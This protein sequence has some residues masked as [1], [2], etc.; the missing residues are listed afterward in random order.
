MNKSFPILLLLVLLTACSSDDG[1]ACQTQIPVEIKEGEGRLSV[2]WQDITEDRIVTGYEFQLELRGELPN[3]TYGSTTIP[4]TT[5]PDNNRFFIESFKSLPF[6]TEFD[7][8]YRVMC[9]NNVGETLGPIPLR[10]LAFGEGCTSPTE[11][12][13]IEITPTSAT[14][15]WEGFDETLWSVSWGANDG[16]G[17]GSFDSPETMITL[18]DLRPG[19]EY[20]VSIRARCEGTDFVLSQLELAPKETFTTP[21]E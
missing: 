5:A 15:E 20:L 8:Y 17:G 4:I 6:Q 9:G 2:T 16:M 3:D 10:T 13:L 12:R 21:A 7:L 11:L 1:E 19:V 18:E 14:L